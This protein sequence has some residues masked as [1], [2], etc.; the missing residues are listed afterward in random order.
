MSNDHVPE[1]FRSLLNDLTRNHRAARAELREGCAAINRVNGARMPPR[2]YS[3]DSKCEE[4]AKHFLAD[5][6]PFSEAEKESLASTIQQAIENWFFDRET[7]RL[8]LL[9]EHP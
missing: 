7:E 6:E 5:H 3:Y 4:L 9:E 8:L 1:P 2:R